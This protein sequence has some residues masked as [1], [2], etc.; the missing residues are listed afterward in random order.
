MIASKSDADRP[1]GP[2]FDAFCADERLSAE[3]R[4]AFAAWCR[5]QVYDAFDPPLEQH[6]LEALLRRWRRAMR[7]ERQRTA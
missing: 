6:E 5:A 2:A 4:Q 3:E 1:L 7:D